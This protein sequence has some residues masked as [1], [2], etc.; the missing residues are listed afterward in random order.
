MP[1]ISGVVGM[2][3]ALMGDDGEDKEEYL[4]KALGNGAFAD[5]ILKGAP[6]AMGV[7]I[8]RRVGAANIVDPLGFTNGYGDWKDKALGLTLGPT[9]GVLNRAAQGYKYIQQGDL[10]KG[11]ENFVPNGISNASKAIR[12]EAE[13]ISN[14]RGEIVMK[15]EDV[16]FLSSVFQAVGLPTTQITDRTWKAGV[17]ADREMYF[18][19]KASEIK[20]DYVEARKAGDSTAE[21]TKAWMELQAARVRQ[22]F[23]RQPMSALQDAVKTNRKR[24]QDVIEGVQFNKGNRQFV[25]GLS[26]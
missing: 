4:R 22:G 11:L 17:V 25:E 5:L 20:R 9:A 1:V 26:G 19:E 8:S 16:D 14:S 13:G 21:A 24:E 3:G 18:K 23:Q 12:F 10:W 6:A 2:I 7:D 15:P